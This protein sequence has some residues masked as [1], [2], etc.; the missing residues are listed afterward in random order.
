MHHT[1]SPPILTPI[2]IKFAKKAGKDDFYSTVKQRVHAYFKERGISYHANR[3]M[4]IK[5]IL[6]M[7]C[8]L[9]LYALILSNWFQGVLLV[10]LFGCLSFVKALIG[11]N[12]SH[13][14]LH[15]G[16]SSNPKINRW[17]GYTFDMIG[18]SSHIWK[19][20]HN[21]YH[22]TFTN[23]PGHDEDIDKA[24]LLRLQPTDK[25]YPFHAFQHL[26][27]P[28]LYCLT[29]FVWI[30]YGDYAWMVR[31]LRKGEL[32]WKDCRQMLLLK[33]ANLFA[34]LVVPLVWLSAP[35]W[36]ILL[37][38]VALQC[39]GSFYMSVIFQLAHIVE[40]VQFPQKNALGAIANEWAVHEMLTT[41]NFARHNRVLSYMVG[42][43]N[44]QIEHH[45]F[46]YICHIHY[47]MIAEIVKKTAE[48]FK[49]PYNEYPTFRAA[50]KSHL[51][52]LKEFGRNA[53]FRT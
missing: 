50:F 12:I 33:A 13:D 10:T 48:E 11:F 19:I 22:H 14:A 15:G 27:A 5:T 3:Q 41:S 4:V 30:W 49:I 6:L 17:L 51:R 23:I 9:G 38:Y 21:G 1:E 52:T 20:S 2:P 25:L 34:F 53:N 45:L 18:T 8:A 28:F 43:L 42:G 39:V 40:N 31:E 29:S 26:Y 32:S 46:P 44:F 7:S 24:I 47:P 35:W 16:Y 36:Q 37:G